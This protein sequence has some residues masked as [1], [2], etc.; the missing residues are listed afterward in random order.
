MLSDQS[1]PINS[2]T[3]VS[4]LMPLL[5]KGRA[6]LKAGEKHLVTVLPH[7]KG[8]DGTRQCLGQVQHD[9]EQEV[10]GE[11][12][13]DRLAGAHSLVGEAQYGV[14]LASSEGLM[15]DMRKATTVTANPNS[16]WSRATSSGKRQTLHLLHVSRKLFPTDGARAL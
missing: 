1:P 15:A 9:L 6:N 8:T 10:D 13:G 5:G 2:S 16:S 14:S 12:P 3:S 11:R 4:D 7:D